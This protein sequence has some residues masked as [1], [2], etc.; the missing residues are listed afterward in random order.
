MRFSGRVNH[1][2]VGCIIPVLQPIILAILC[3]KYSV[4]FV[5]VSDAPLFS[6]IT[7]FPAHFESQA[8]T[9]VA[10]LTFVRHRIHL[11]VGKAQFLFTSKISRS[12]GRS[13]KY[14]HFIIV[15]LSQQNRQEVI[16][17]DQDTPPLAFDQIQLTFDLTFTLRKSNPTTCITFAQSPSL[18]PPS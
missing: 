8:T 1:S 18:R 17:N 11:P 12:A 7:D 4:P 5:E 3:F 15:V 16:S 14:H 10:L 13:T 9:R 6:Q 2:I